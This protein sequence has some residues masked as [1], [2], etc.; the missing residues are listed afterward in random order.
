VKHALRGAILPVVS[1]I[2]PAAAGILTGSLILERIFNI[3]GIG[4][5]FIEAAGQRDFT[6]AMGIVLLSTVMV[7]VMNMLV[8]LSYALIDPRVKVE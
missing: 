2:G 8:D 1:Y 5:H 3:P 7:Y 6:L 4:S